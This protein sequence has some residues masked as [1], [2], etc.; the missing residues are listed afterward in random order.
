MV[1]VCQGRIK[2]APYK[3][4]MIL[5]TMAC[6]PILAPGWWFGCWF[7]VTLVPQHFLYQLMPQRWD[8]R[9]QQKLKEPISRNEEDIHWE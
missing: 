1:L 5:G 7:I 8:D 9:A 3:L 4:W 6:K 2:W